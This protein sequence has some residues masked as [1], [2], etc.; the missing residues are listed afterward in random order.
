MSD[1]LAFGEDSLAMKR[2]GWFC[3]ILLL[4]LYACRYIAHIEAIGAHIAP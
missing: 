2:M 3:A 1:G 4:R